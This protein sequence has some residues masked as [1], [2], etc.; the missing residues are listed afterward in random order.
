MTSQP[1][2]H[3]PPALTLDEEPMSEEEVQ[4]LAEWL[5]ERADEAGVDP[6]AAASDLVGIAG[7]APAF[8]QDYIAAPPQPAARHWRIDG[9]GSAEWSM[10]HV[11]Q[12]TARLRALEEQRDGYI[13]RITHWFTQAARAEQARLAFFEAHLE[14]YAV[15]WRAEDPKHNKTLTLPS[16]KVATRAY[17]AKPA[18]EDDAAVI[19]W[20]K[21]HLEGDELASVVRTKETVIAAGFDRVARLSDEIDGAVYKVTLACGHSFEHRVE[22]SPVTGELEP[23]FDVGDIEPCGNCPPD[24]EDES[25]RGQ[26]QPVAD[27]RVI[28]MWTRTRVVDQAGELIP[29]ARVE[30]AKVVPTVKPGA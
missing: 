13:E 29:G 1:L 15:E 3:L 6:E 22:K 27:V 10:A 2:D 12:A 25:Y 18:V 26:H 21:T 16:G 5:V 20:A 19:A 7:E 4:A 23:L 24:P 9:P 14:R 8:A 30:P 17:D 28:D 11:A